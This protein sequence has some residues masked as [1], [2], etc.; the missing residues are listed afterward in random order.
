MEAFNQ[1]HSAQLQRDVELNEFLIGSW[2]AFCQHVPV[3][4][5]SWATASRTLTQEIPTATTS[6]LLGLVTTCSSDSGKRNK[7][8]LGSAFEKNASG[9]L[10]HTVVRRHASQMPRIRAKRGFGEGSAARYRRVQ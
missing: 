7:N 6:S 2:E 4:Q 10:G 1:T 9:S 8:F 3:L 5:R